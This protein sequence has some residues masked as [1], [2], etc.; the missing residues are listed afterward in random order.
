MEEENK[1]KNAFVN[2]KELDCE[3]RGNWIKM[4]K[5][6][7]TIRTPYINENRLDYEKGGIE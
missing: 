1:N 5:R 2:D 6:K 7:M 3:K 4:S